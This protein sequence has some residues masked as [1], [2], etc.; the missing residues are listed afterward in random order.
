MLKLNFYRALGLATHVLCLWMIA[1]NGQASVPL[2]LQPTRSADGPEQAGY[3]H[4]II[5]V[6]PP[7]IV[8]VGT[9]SDSGIKVGVL[10]CVE[11]IVTEIGRNDN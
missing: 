7:E 9:F 10:L 5:S 6:L 2:F 11:L 4:Q 3:I 1:L 8:A